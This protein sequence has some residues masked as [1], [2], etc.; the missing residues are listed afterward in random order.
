MKK[1]LLISA[2]FFALSHS[3]AAQAQL[4]FPNF[5]VQGQDESS[6]PSNPGAN[7]VGANCYV[8]DND[9][10]PFEGGFNTLQHYFWVPDPAVCAGINGQ[11]ACW[12]FIEETEA[13]TPYSDPGI[14][15]FHINDNGDGTTTA[16]QVYVVMDPFTMYN[17]WA[18]WFF[19]N[20]DDG[21]SHAR[22]LNSPYDTGGGSGPGGY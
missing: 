9:A 6:C 16:M 2:L 7:V 3:D 17:P 20:C 10:N 4:N 8:E 11:D 14:L 12:T 21:Q 13:G 1:L 15:G 18:D 19:N 22:C 5:W